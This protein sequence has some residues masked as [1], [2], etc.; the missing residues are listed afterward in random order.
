MVC[1]TLDRD[2]FVFVG[3]LDIVNPEVKA[4]KVNAIKTSFIPAS[5]DHIVNLALVASVESQMEGRGVDES[6]VVDSK[7]CHFT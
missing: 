4:P 5:D 1:R 6:N 7:V 3:N 2:A